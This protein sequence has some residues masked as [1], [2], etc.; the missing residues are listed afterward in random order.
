M[1]YIMETLGLLAETAEIVSFYAE[2]MAV[3]PQNR[4]L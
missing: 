2:I 1:F 3:K 4:G